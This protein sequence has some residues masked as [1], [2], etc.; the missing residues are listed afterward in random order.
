MIPLY[1]SQYFRLGLSFTIL[2][3]LLLYCFIYYF[4]DQ[5]PYSYEGYFNNAYHYYEDKRATGGQEDFLSLLGPFDS[6]WYLFIAEE[7]YPKVHHQSPIRNLKDKALTFCFYPL[8]PALIKIISVITHDPELSAFIISNLSFL[9]AY[10]LLF[11]LIASQFN[12]KTAF[13]TLLLM[14]VFPFSLTYRLYYTE[15]L[16]L[17]ILAIFSYALLHQK[18]LISAL[19]LFGSNILRGAGWL[20]NPVYFYF[21]YQQYRLKKIPFIK[22]GLLGIIP[23]SSIIIWSGYNWLKTGSPFFFYQGVTVPWGRSLLP[24]TNLINNLG[25]ILI[26]PSLPRHGFHYS[27]LEVGMMIIAF[28][29]LITS[30]KILPKYLWY[31][32]WALFILPLLITDLASFSRYQSVNFPL[33]IAASQRINGWQLKLLLISFTFA[34]FV[35][36]IK[37]VN[38][39]LIT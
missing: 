32:G 31:I 10:C 19:A 16:F 22:L 23:I 35:Y 17:L 36:T 29:I 13:K 5:L 33:F 7:G 20:L 30:K 28:T 8:Y 3:N 37:F 27:Q 4:H 6:Q 9:S 14:T 39:L 11:Y 15:S 18:W 12:G 24:L 34:L 26:L 2:L 38:W 21:I 25:K 1:R